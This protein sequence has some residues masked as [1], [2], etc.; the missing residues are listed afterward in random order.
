MFDFQVNL[1]DFLNKTKVVRNQFLKNYMFH[2]VG[3]L[4]G[5]VQMNK[6]KYNYQEFLYG[7]YNFV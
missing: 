5:E 6:Y 7:V 4:Q 2:L 3:V 1:S